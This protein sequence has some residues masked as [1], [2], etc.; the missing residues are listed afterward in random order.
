VVT[1]VANRSEPVDD[2]SHVAAIRGR[3]P[4][5]NFNPT[6]HSQ[7]DLEDVWRHLMGPLG[8]SGRSLWLMLVDADGHP[9]PHLSQIEQADSPPDDGELAGFADIVR[10]L[11]DE[12]VPGG[13]I[14][15]LRSRPGGPGL[16]PNDR[17]WARALYDVG[18]LS[19]VPVEVVHRA[20]D[21]DLVPVPMD[22]ALPDS[23]A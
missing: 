18:R 15:F 22:D 13:R 11:V 5:M 16:T 7:Q 20:C 9:V 1:E 4:V 21:H 3:L 8:F 23:A 10:G 12:F 14:A 6:I 17:A 2:R 19:G